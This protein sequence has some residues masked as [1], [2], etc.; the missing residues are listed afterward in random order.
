MTWEN[1]GIYWDIDH[2]IPLSLFDFSQEINIKICYNWINLRPLEK[3]VNITKSNIIQKN[4]I[5]EH[6]KDIQK[7]LENNT[8]YEYQSL[9]EMINWLRVNT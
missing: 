9:S 5:N 3:K 7:Y 6:I 1:Y 8:N 2:V 4:Y